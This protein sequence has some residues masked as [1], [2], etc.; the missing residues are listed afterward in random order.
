MAADYYKTLGV[1]KDATSDDIKKAYRKLALK[2]HPDKNPGNKEA[3]DKFKKM[4]EAYAVLSDAEKRKEYDNFGSDGF[5]QHYTQEDIFRGFD[6]NEILRGFGMGGGSGAG[7]R[8]Y[9]SYQHQ[10]HNGDPFADFF[11]GGQQHYRSPAQKGQDLE[12]NLTISLEESVLGAEKKIALNKDGKIDEINIKIPSGIN[13]GKKLRLNGKG[14]PGSHGGP[15]GDL[16][17]NISI[18]P[19]PIFARDGNDIYVEKELKFSQVVLGTSIDVPTI[20]GMVKRLKIPPGTQNNTKIRMKGY[21]VQHIKD[22]ERGDQYVK[23]LVSVPKRL[24]A[25]QTELIKKLADEGI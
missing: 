13:A 16:Y 15:A 14:L 25:S 20:D 10:Q 4:S 3:E 11:G 17:L 2:Y 24:T 6:L 22:S 5:R 18:Q 23:I 9:S 19:H 8:Q 12:Y 21:G 7:R 1:T